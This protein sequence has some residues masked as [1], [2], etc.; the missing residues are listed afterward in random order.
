VYAIAVDRIRFG[1]AI[2]R[3]ERPVLVRG[4]NDVPV[5]LDSR[6]SFVIML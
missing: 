4:F 6:V 1:E 3:D 5:S 2:G